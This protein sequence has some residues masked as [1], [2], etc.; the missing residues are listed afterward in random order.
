[1]VTC[2][3][4]WG[5]IHGHSAMTCFLPILTSLTLV[6]WPCTLRKPHSILLQKG[7]QKP[8]EMLKVFPKLLSHSQTVALSN[9]GNRFVL[10]PSHSLAPSSTHS[11]NLIPSPCAGAAA[12]SRLACGTFLTSGSLQRSNVLEDW[13]N[14]Q[15]TPEELEKSK[16]VRL[17][18][19]GRALCPRGLE[20]G[21]GCGEVTRREDKDKDIAGGMTGSSSQKPG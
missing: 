13:P 7:H 19:T 1:M 6:R 21:A 11:R 16:S 5:L 9:L 15:S 17:E 14:S 20:G 4:L 2:P 10:S 12:N 18:K 8:R 3:E